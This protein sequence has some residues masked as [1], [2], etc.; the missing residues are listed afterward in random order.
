MRL[1]IKKGTLQ[2]S[3]Y[4]KRDNFGFNI[5]NFPNLSGNIPTNQSY[6][7]FIS[8][9]VRYSRCCQHFVDFRERT[10]VLVKKL[11][12]QHFNFYK[13]CRTFNKFAR[14]YACLLKKYKEFKV[15]DLSILLDFKNNPEDA[16]PGA[17]KKTPW[18]LNLL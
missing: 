16:Q 15:Y 14:R 6:G 4:D 11:I 17:L 12:K 9:L 5:V 8:Q 1:E 18:D 10:L 13:L 2:Y 3:L 7:I